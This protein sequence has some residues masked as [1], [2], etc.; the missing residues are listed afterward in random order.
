MLKKSE[1]EMSN[2]QSSTNFL[3]P[4]ISSP[5]PRMVDSSM[6]R[7]SMYGINGKEIRIG[8]SQ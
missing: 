4:R 2:Q 3:S 5:S 1:V 7:D 8:V 6:A